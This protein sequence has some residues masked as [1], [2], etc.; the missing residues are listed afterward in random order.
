MSIVKG[1]STRFDRGACCEQDAQQYDIWMS[2]HA[3]LVSA[4][5]IAGRFVPTHNL[6]NI[7]HGTREMSYKPPT[8]QPQLASGIHGEH[9]ST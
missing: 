8:V 4:S 9:R 7:Q 1:Q 6:S 3:R 2:F 5:T